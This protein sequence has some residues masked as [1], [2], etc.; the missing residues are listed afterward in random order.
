MAE[1]PL[2]ELLHEVFRRS[3]IVRGVRRAEAV[4]LWRRVVGPEV[5][6][7]ARAVTLQHGTLVVDVPDPETALHLGLQRHHVLRAYAEHLGPGV[8]REIRFRVGRPPESRA[9]AAD[10]RAGAGG[11]PQGTPK[12]EAGAADPVAQPDPRA[13]SRLARALGE[14]PEPLAGAALQAGAALLALQAR[15]RAARWRPCPVCGVLREPLPDEPAADGLGPGPHWCATCRRHAEHPKVARQ[16]SRLLLDPDASTPLL[17]DDERLVARRAAAALAADEC[18]ALLPRALADPSVLP[19]LERLA[20]SQAALLADIP[21]E[22]VD[23]DALSPVDPRVL[24]AIG[25]WA[26]ARSNAAKETPP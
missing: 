10:G 1:R 16:A 18:L 22:A 26:G 24:R 12:G 21:L 13:L 2:A 8:V 5:A 11:A 7:F 15:R 4:V 23:D 25:R 19:S 17:S 14:A 9:S 6:A 20:R 3:G